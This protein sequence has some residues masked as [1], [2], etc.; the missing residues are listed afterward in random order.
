MIVL[1]KR[2]A[3]YFLLVL[4]VC[5]VTTGLHADEV[6][7]CSSC[8]GGCT[9]DFS[10]EKSI[11]YTEYNNFVKNF[12]FGLAIFG[13]ITTLIFLIVVIVNREKE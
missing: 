1:N 12:Y 4:L 13:I 3:L 9:G 6:H 7:K 2:V 8:S 5:I 11:D 10:A